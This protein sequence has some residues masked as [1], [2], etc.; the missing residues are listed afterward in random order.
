MN[1]LRSFCVCVCVCV[2]VCVCVCGGGACVCVCG[3]VCVCVW[4]CVCV[5]VCVCVFV[6]VCVCVCVFVCVCVR[7]SVFH[8]AISCTALGMPGHNN[9]LIHPIPNLI[10]ISVQGIRT[11]RLLLKQHT[12][13]EGRRDREKSHQMRIAIKA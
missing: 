6:C 9:T 5:C 7:E 11:H 2:F 1:T 12:G 10:S 4:G 8:N 13:R 3:G